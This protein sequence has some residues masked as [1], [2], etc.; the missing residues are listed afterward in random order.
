MV[1]P[2]LSVPAQHH[3][4]TGTATAKRYMVPTSTSGMQCRP[5][6]QMCTMRS[7]MYSLGNLQAHQSRDMC[8]QQ[9]A[10]NMHSCTQGYTY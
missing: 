10:T 5:S 8:I 4:H 2:P 3:L 6:T 7:T 9:L 1:T